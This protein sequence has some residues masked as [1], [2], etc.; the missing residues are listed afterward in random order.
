MN[1]NVPSYILPV[2]FGCAWGLLASVILAL[3][4]LGP[5]PF[6]S[7]IAYTILLPGVLGKLGYGILNSLITPSR[8][9]TIWF[10]PFAMLA[11]TILILLIITFFRKI[12]GTTN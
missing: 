11:G 7:G 3:S 8:M 1:Q 5:E 10:I 4:G 2:L 6:H 12:H 9:G